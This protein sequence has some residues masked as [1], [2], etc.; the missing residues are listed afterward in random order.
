MHTDYFN[1]KTVK[2]FQTIIFASTCFGLHKPSPGSCSLR[3]AKGTILIAIYK[4]LLKYSVLSLHISFS[5]V[6]CVCVCVCVCVLCTV[7][8]AQCIIVINIVTLAK[9]RL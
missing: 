9:H 4:S 2:T 5:P 3:L 1:S 8:N 7:Q 6:V